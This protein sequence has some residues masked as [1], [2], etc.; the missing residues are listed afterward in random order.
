MSR[1]YTGA[2]SLTVDERED[3]E[4]TFMAFSILRCC[5]TIW[6]VFVVTYCFFALEAWM[7]R[8]KCV[9]APSSHFVVDCIVDLVSKLIFTSVVVDSHGDLINPA[10]RSDSRVKELQSLIGVVWES[11]SDALVVTSREI[12]TSAT[13]LGQSYVY[14]ATSSPTVLA[15]ITENGKTSE[16]RSRSGSTQTIKQIDDVIKSCLSDEEHGE[17]EPELS[18][19]NFKFIDLGPGSSARHVPI[20]SNSLTHSIASSGFYELICRAWALFDNKK[21]SP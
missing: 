10:A 12:H 3:I 21:A 20:D 2:P 8:G 6:T 11:S 13:V 17:Q 5:C 15:M 9:Y 19:F 1:R 7:F 16:F 4:R 14:N 18:S